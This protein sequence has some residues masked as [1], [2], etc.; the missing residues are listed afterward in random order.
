MGV[1]KQYTFTYT[2]TLRV[3]RR[4]GV[5]RGSE[6]GSHHEEKNNAENTTSDRFEIKSAIRAAIMRTTMALPTDF[7]DLASQAVPAKEQATH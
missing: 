4:L 3:I 6:E 7:H 5:G 1:T 2:T